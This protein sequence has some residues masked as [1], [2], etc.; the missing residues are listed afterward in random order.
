MLPA[1][2]S[3][4][5]ERLFSVFY[6]MTEQSNNKDAKR[7]SFSIFV[8]TCIYLIDGGQVL[9]ALLLPEFGWDPG[10]VD[11][12]GSL[13]VVNLSIKLVRI[14]DLRLSTL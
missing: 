8:C 1:S 11:Q 2:W 13:D 3:N 7:G 5:R 6:I 12:A 4:M 9:R 10:I 14:L